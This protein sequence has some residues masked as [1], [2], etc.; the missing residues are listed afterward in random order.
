MILHLGYLQILLVVRADLLDCTG[1]FECL[2]L[3]SLDHGG[4]PLADGFELIVD[5]LELVLEHLFLRERILVRDSLIQ[6]DDPKSVT[7]IASIIT[8]IVGACE[9]ETVELIQTGQATRL[10][11]PVSEGL[12]FGTHTRLGLCLTVDQSRVSFLESHTS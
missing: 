2:M 1:L 11:Q 9:P 3:A 10:L 5:L 7:G 6:F 8:R 4:A 12:P